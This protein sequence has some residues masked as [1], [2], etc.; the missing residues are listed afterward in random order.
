MGV[1]LAVIPVQR[2]ED[3]RFGTPVVEHQAGMTGATGT[4]VERYQIGN[5]PGEDQ[6]RAT[7]G[8]VQVGVVGHGQVTDV[9][10][11]RQQVSFLGNGLQTIGQKQRVETIQIVP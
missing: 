6:A 8:F 9:T 7:A 5:M 4:A 2:I 1:L 11:E 10:V 3:Q